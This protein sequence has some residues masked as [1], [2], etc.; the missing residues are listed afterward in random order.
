MDTLICTHIAHAHTHTHARMH[1]CTRTHACTHARTR[2]HACTHARTRTHACTHARTSTHACT[3]ACTH[4]H[5]HARTHARTQHGHTNKH[6]QFVLFQLCISLVQWV[7]KVGSKW[8]KWAWCTS[9]HN[10][11]PG[12]Q[13]FPCKVY[14]HSLQYN[15]CVGCY[16]SNKVDLVERITEKILESTQHS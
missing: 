16:E 1:A 7:N 15:S 10:H 8:V 12:Q 14:Q 3:H 4:S 9:L 2:T 5:A 11:S 6:T 13:V